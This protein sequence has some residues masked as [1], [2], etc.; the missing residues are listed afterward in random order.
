M[1]RVFYAVEAGGSQPRNRQA[2]QPLHYQ[3]AGLCF[4]SSFTVPL[5]TARAKRRLSRPPRG[6]KAHAAR[7]P[8]APP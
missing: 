2:L 3:T 7:G 1:G 6:G 5:A 4:L 8:G